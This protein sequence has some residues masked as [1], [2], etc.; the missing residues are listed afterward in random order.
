LTK[1]EYDELINYLK[2]ISDEKYKEFSK[3]LA[4]G[5]NN[6]LGVQIPKLRIIAKEITRGNYT[7]FLNL[8]Q[9]N[10]HE[11]TMIHGLVIG[12][13]KE[14]YKNTIEHI[15]KF[16]PHITNW[17]ICDSFCTKFNSV[18]KNRK[19]FL[20]FLKECINTNKEFYIRFA[21]VMLK[22]IYVD[23]EYIDIVLKILNDIS[24]EGYYVK[25]AVAWTLCDSF[26]K[27]QDKTMN[28]L[29][30]NNLDN[31]T[32]NKAIQKIIESNRVNEKTKNLVRNMKIK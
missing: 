28:Y 24:H 3:N 4:P 31:F 25:M 5:V 10:Y 12:Y 18:M 16:L 13:I 29:K 1:N 27:F 26:I 8:T 17:A 32:Y 22:N 23:K 9:N 15:K 7:E 14:D 20:K 6:M 30:L 11:E 19:E 2:E 21:V